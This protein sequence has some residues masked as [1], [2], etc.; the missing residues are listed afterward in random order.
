MSNTQGLV[1]IVTGAGSGIGLAIAQ[2][3]AKHGPVVLVGRR[4]QP[5]LDAG[6]SLGTDTKHWLAI[7]ADITNPCD[8]ERVINETLDAFA[9]ID[10]LVNNAGVG[11]YAPL[12]ELSEQQIE[13]LIGVNLTAPLLLTR[14]ALV[15]LAEHSGCVVSIGSRAATDPFPGLGVYGC[16]KSGIEGLARCITSEYPTIRAFTVHP[17]AV[18]TQMLRS[19]LSTD[20]LPSDQILMPDEI[21]LAVEAFVLGH[22]QQP[23]GSSIVVEKV[24]EKVD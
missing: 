6:S 7:P 14:L 19:I 21:A 12:G 10:V 1:S 9:R 13:H 2:R 23:S 24:V 15:S 11:T 3:L 4:I 17:G 18:E 8:R 16:T 5:L 20:E 22:H